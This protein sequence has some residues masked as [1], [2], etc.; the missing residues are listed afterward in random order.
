MQK[1]RF[2]LFLCFVVFLLL[3][4]YLTLRV[5]LGRRLLGLQIRRLREGAVNLARL[6][7]EA[8]DPVELLRDDVSAAVLEVGSLLE[9]PRDELRL[10]ILVILL[11]C[12]GRRRGGGRHRSGHLGLLGLGL[13]L[14]LLLRRR[15]RRGRD[16]RALVL[17]S[18]S[19][20][21]DLRALPRGVLRED[22]LRSPRAVV[23]VLGL[24]HAAELSH[25]NARR[26][27]R[28]L[29]GGAHRRGELDPVIGLLLGRV[30]VL[31]LLGLLDGRGRSRGHRLATQSGRN[32][33]LQE[34]VQVR[35]SHRNEH[36]G[37]GHFRARVFQSVLL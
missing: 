20:L 31:L 18:E 1:K 37:R 14:L 9:G 2:F 29:E 16:A 21:A 32:G 8:A 23:S 26:D 22:Q 10:R 34:R 12:R 4:C 30:R 15:G 35:H 25:L 7:V 3:S 27:L 28:G 6:L 17:A 36:L 13:L 5:G 24:E 19:L 11:L 33:T